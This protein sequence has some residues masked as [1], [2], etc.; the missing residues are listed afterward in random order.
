MH[1]V[2]QTWWQYA[3]T[4][5]ISFNAGVSGET[6]TGYYDPLLNYHYRRGAGG[7]LLLAFGLL[8]QKC[9]EARLLFGAAAE[10][11]GWRELDPIHESGKDWTTLQETPTSTLRGLA[12]A[13]ELGDEAVYA[14]L[15]AHAE[16]HYEPTWDPS[17]GEFTW[18][19]GL[20]E[21]H[22]RGQYNAMMM[23]SEA[24]SEGA[25]WRMV[26][27]PNLRKFIDPTIHSVDFPTVCLSQAWYDVD[28]RCLVVSTDAGTPG[29]AGQRTS[30]RVSNVDP[31]HC[32][33]T[34]DGW[35]AA[36]WRAVNGELEIATT[37]GQHTV[38]I[39]H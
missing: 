4:N 9:E 10:S 16:T 33:V 31:Q 13:R 21:P 15:K 23:I 28:R 6:L 32:R 5:Y 26:N 7:G 34:M 29:A 14:K 18:G 25:W 35:P 30:F 12:I 39:W 22:P 1:R 20:H 37:V 17:T 36:D 19:F 8:S 24:G 38:V 27:E 3:R 2:F 11:L